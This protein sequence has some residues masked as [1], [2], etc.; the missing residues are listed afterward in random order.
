[1]NRQPACLGNNPTFES[2]VK[3]TKPLLPN[4]EELAPLV[5]DIFESRVVTKGDRLRVFEELVAEHLGVK[6]AVAVSSCTA[7]LMLVYRLLGLNGEVIVPSFTFMATVSALVWAGS[8]PLFA[9]ID[10]DTTN[11]NPSAAEAAITPD[12]KAIVAVHNGGNPADIDDLKQVAERHHLRLIFDAAHGFGSLYQDQPLGSQGDVGVFSLSPTKLLV[13]GEG[14]IVATNDDAL[15]G[16]VR[17]GREY[18]NSGDYDSA[19]AGINARLPEFNALLGQFGLTNLEAAAQHR[20]RLAELYR[21]RLGR[22]PG[23]SFQKVRPGNRSSYKDFSITIDKEAF[24]LTRDALALALKAE[25]IETRKYYDPPVHRQTAYT[26]YAPHSDTLP[27]TER[28]S[29]RILNLPIW[30]DMESS[31]VAGVCAAIESAHEFA[32][33]IRRALPLVNNDAVCQGSLV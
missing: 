19:F 18:G 17:M 26:Q 16:G 7:G 14:G 1:M 4:Y 5:R 24:G 31:I 10:P 11:L 12:T 9:D 27:H 22:L 28:L 29:F 32:E 13:A 3:I 25:N 2:K 8:R 21:A 30:S 23:V 6:N 33:D 15:A 20:N